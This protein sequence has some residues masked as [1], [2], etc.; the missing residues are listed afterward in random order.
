M[1]LKCAK[2]QKNTKTLHPTIRSTNQMYHVKGTCVIC[3]R[4]KHKIIK[5]KQN[6]EIKNYI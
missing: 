6:F 5:T 1:I 4:K 2:C 3:G